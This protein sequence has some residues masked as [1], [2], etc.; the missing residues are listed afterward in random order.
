MNPEDLT[1]V[2]F[3]GGMMDYRLRIADGKVSVEEW[4]YNCEHEKMEQG[5]TQQFGTTAQAWQWIGEQL[6]L[7]EK[8]IQ[9]RKVDKLPNP[10]QSPQH[11]KMLKV[12]NT[13]IGY[14]Y[15]QQDRWEQTDDDGATWY[16]TFRGEDEIRRMHPTVQDLTGYNAFPKGKQ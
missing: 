7:V 8:V 4:G 14:R 2:Q 16:F 1:I 3:A 13:T 15:S 9:V 6:Q 11:T 10:P 12:P 5:K